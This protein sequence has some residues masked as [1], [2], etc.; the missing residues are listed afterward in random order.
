MDEDGLL[1]RL[2]G[3]EIAM[4]N[5]DVSDI[6]ITIGRISE[7]LDN[8]DE[9]IDDLKVCHDSAQ[10]CVTALQ[11]ELASRPSTKDLKDT[12]KDVSIHSTYF[13]IIGAI[14]IIIAGFI[15]AL[16]LKLI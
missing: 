14:L 11:V 10:L 2:R 1:E 13:K 7:K 5:K 15:S 3:K 8:I 4:L 9:K 16:S 12:M 6:K